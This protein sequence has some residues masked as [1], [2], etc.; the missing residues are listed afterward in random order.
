M[1]QGIV[2]MLHDL[3]SFIGTAISKTESL[4]DIEVEFSQLIEKGLMNPEEWGAME[5]IEVQRKMRL[6]DDLLWY[7]VNE[8]K[9]ANNE[10]RN[11]MNEMFKKKITEEMQHEAK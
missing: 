10:L 3:D 2:R 4:S 9:Q 8:L 5:R 6:L 7:T 11:T 1:T